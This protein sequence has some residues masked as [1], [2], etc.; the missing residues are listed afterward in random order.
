MQ[1]GWHAA[2]PAR[3]KLCYRRRMLPLK[4]HINL[5]K[6]VIKSDANFFLKVLANTGS[7]GRPKGG[8][9]PG[10][11]LP[12]PEFENDDVIIM[13][14]TRKM[15]S[16]IVYPKLRLKRRKSRENFRLRLWPL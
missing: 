5:L 8:G 1:R 3:T 2:I 13:L 4:L 16:R 6:C 12:S 9:Q 14:F 7:H 11:V 15:P 10:A